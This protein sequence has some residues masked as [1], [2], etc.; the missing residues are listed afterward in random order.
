MKGVGWGG[1]GRVVN[2]RF[3]NKQD[4]FQMRSESSKHTAVF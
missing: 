1:G 3:F 4:F 2:R